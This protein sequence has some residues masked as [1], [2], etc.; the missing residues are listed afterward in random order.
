MHFAAGR[1]SLQAS[2]GGAADMGVSTGVV[3]VNPEA[4]RGDEVYRNN[5]AAR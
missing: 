3:K 5:R 2:Q 4:K 1:R